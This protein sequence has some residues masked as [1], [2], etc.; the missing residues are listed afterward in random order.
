ML[1]QV[2]Q[3]NATANVDCNSDIVEY[4][5]IYKNDDIIE[6]FETVDIKPT[7]EPKMK[8]IVNL[9]MSKLIKKQEWK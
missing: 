8:G 2:I 9:A 4:D 6:T 3:S 7:Q 1:N 5:D